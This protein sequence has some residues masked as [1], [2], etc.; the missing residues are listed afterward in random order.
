MMKEVDQMLKDLGVRQFEGPA[1]SRDAF[2]APY[3]ILVSSGVHEEGK[4]DI[5]PAF[6]EEDAIAHYCDA[7]QTFLGGRQV[8]IWRH[9]PTLECHERRGL[10]G[11]VRKEWKVY[12][13]LTAYEASEMKEILS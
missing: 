11:K 6:S 7:L 4:D 2:E 12:S 5:V 9:R 10:G 3:T 8:V 13:R 1:R